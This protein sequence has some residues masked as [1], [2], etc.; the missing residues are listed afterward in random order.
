MYKAG[1]TTSKFFH[2]SYRVPRAAPPSR[3][4]YSRDLSVRQIPRWSH[5]LTKKP[6]LDVTSFARGRLAL[7]RRTSSSL[8]EHYPIGHVASAFQRL[9]ALETWDIASDSNQN[10]LDVRVSTGW[11]WTGFHTS[12][13]HPLIFASIFFFFSK[14]ITVISL[15][16]FWTSWHR[17]S[18]PFFIYVPRLILLL[19][20]WTNY[21]RFVAHIC[22]YMYNFS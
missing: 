16:A 18:D 17:P 7:F 15:V 3:Y 14:H 22:T 12:F 10:P 4:R 9:G 1:S 20:R 5:W 2:H 11:L 13:N 21:L 19:G 6:S 8:P